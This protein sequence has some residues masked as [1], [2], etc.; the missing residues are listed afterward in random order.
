MRTRWG[1]GRR[2]G[3]DPCVTEGFV[4]CAQDARSPTI[5]RFR[6]ENREALAALLVQVLELAGEAGLGRVGVVAVDG[7]GSRRTHLYGANRRRSQPQEQ[8]DQMLR[9]GMVDAEEDVLFGEDN[10]PSQ[11]AEDWCDPQ[12]RRTAKRRGANRTG[13]GAAAE[14]RK[15]LLGGP[16]CGSRRNA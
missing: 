15:V 3:R 1:S 6:K 13:R 14:E 9:G 8:V 2:G 10:N 11:V 7:T 16:G 4:I 5:A 12:T